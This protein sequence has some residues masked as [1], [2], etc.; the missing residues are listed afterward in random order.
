LISL[1]SSTW[2]QVYKDITPSTR[3]LAISNAS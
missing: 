2:Q 3:S 1:L